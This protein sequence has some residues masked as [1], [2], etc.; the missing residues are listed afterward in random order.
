MREIDDIIVMWYDHDQ[1]EPTYEWSG[2]PWFGDKS[3]YYPIDT[4]VDGPYL[5]KPQFPFEN[6]ADPHHFKYVHG[7]YLDAEFSDYNV[8]GPYAENVMRLMFGGGKDKTWLTP[9]GP[10]L[11]YV[12]NFFWGASLG[13]ARFRIDDFVC[14]HLPTLTPVDDDN[15]IFFST[16]TATREPGDDGDT[17]HG[18][19]GQMMAAQHWQ[20]RNDF[21]IWQNQKY[22]VKPI[23]TGTE[24]Q[25]RYAFIRR[26]FD[27]FYPNPVYSTGS[28]N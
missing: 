3:N 4:T 27:Q 5:A 10:V 1:A 12:D 25:T 15:A 24:E 13:V 19:S 22:I 17:P 26:H 8:D 23:F 28:D 16:V 11:G 2:L 14:I 18:R 20:I 7:S 21:H 9:D 6:S